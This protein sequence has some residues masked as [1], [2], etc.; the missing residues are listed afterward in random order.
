[1]G[2]IEVDV[3]WIFLKNMGFKVPYQLVKPKK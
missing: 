3:D 2:S 1:M